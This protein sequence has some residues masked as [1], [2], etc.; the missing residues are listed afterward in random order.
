MWFSQLITRFDMRNDKLPAF[1]SGF[2]LYTGVIFIMN[3]CMLFP[4][5]WVPAV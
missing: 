3:L 1:V 5:T 4:L 2:R